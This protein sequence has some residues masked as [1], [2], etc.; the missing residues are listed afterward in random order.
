MN[1][2][3]LFHFAPKQLYQ[4]NLPK[5][6]LSNCVFKDERLSQGQ[7]GLVFNH[8]SPFETVNCRTLCFLTSETKTKQSHTFKNWAFGLAELFLK[9]LNYSNNLR[10]DLA[11]LNSMLGGELELFS[12]N[13]MRSQQQNPL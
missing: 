8:L 11:H 10:G 7:R 2:V 3:L 12:K 13:I 6:T 4:I 5:K 1:S 9:Y